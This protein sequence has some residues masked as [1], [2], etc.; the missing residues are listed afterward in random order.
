MAIL[1]RLKDRDQLDS[2]HQRRLD[3]NGSLYL[4][5]D[6]GKLS[7][8]A[9]TRDDRLVKRALLYEAVSLA[10]GAL[11]TLDPKYTEE[12]PD[13]EQNPQGA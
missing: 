1:I 11:C 12:A 8:V 10:T 5:R 4:V 7:P 6:P 13:A 2:Y 3:K 9:Y